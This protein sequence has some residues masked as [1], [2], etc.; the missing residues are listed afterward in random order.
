M[1]ASW[2]LGMLA[3]GLFVG[4]V[5]HN[6]PAFAASRAETSKRCNDFANRKAPWSSATAVRDRWLVYRVCV[7]KAGHRP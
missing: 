1:S 4:V 5:L 7:R 3:L 2:P 6:E